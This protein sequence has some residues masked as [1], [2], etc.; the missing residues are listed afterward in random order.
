MSALAEIHAHVGARARVRRSISRTTTKRCKRVFFDFIEIWHKRQIMIYT[1]NIT[2]PDSPPCGLYVSNNILGGGE[3][4]CWR[5]NV[6]GMWK[7]DPNS[8]WAPYH[9]RSG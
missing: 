5:R 3:E 9:S 2:T 6:A 7:G 1:K 8:M 4:K